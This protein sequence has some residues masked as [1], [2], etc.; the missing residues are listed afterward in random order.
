MAIIYIGSIY[1]PFMIEELKAMNSSIDYAAETFQSSLI[2]GIS[3]FCKELKIITAPNVSTYPKIKKVRFD[4]IIFQYDGLDGYHVF[5]GFINLPILKH[6]SKAI[7]VL[8]A[9]YQ[10]SDPYIENKIIV[11]GVHSP[12]LLPL[13]ALKKNIKVCLIVPDLPEFMSGRNS[14]LFLLAK[15]IDRW[16][17]NV[18]LRRVDSYVLFSPHM[19]E[20]LP[21]KGQPW[22]HLEGI[23]N[24]NN[25]IENTYPKES[26]KIILYTGNL[27]ARMGI[28]NLLDAFALI[29][30][31]NYRLWIRGTGDCK[32]I[33]LDASKFDSRIIYWD[34]MT[35]E[36]LLILQKRA[37]ILI[38]P[39]FSSQEFTRYFFPSKT[40]EY[41]ASGTPTVMSRLACIPSEYD[42]YLFYFDE[43]SIDGIKNKIIDICERKQ[44]ELEAFGKAAAEFV[45]REK[46]EIKQAGKILKLLNI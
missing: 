3:S 5:T 22:L 43:E 2:N 26:E 37:T 4:K 15:K 25:I 39:V 12:F 41:L 33:V 31:S 11:Y 17:I 19:K 34:H 23:L 1:P 36:E 29:P 16:L 38:N 35:K 18:C 42:K 7:R 28:K 27:S 10:M 13:L 46:N 44:E 21:V 20:K 40:M 14:K 32:K 30:F 9:I 45:I 24:T 6:I 8:R